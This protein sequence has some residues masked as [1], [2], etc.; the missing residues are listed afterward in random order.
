[1]RILVGWDDS[2]N[3]ELIGL[4]LN[5]D[6]H[7][8][9][10]VHDGD[11]L[12]RAAT[13]E[14]PWDVVLLAIDFPDVARGYEVFTELRKR[15]PDVPVVGA[16]RADE[17]VQ[18][19]RFLTAGMRTYVLRDTDGDFV[20]LLLSTLESTVQA[21]RA[22]RDQYI[23]GKLREEVEAVR[24]FGEAMIE[25]PPA[26]PPAYTIAARYEPSELHVRGG[27]P[28]A[29]A[30]G[31]FYD[32]FPVDRHRTAI[33][34]ADA[35]GHGMQACLS[36]SILQTHLQMLQQRRWRRPG[37]L[38]AEL[39]RRFCAHRIV[40]NRGNLA[41]FFCGI[42]HHDKHQL[43]WTSAGHPPP[44]M[45]DRNSETIAPI[46]P[47]QSAGPPLGVDENFHYP[48][49]TT[50]LPKRCRLIVY[51]DGLT[52]ASPDENSGIQFGLDGV[53][54]TLRRMR[55][56]SAE[57]VVQALLI[58]SHAFTRGGGRHDDTSVLVLERQG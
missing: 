56:R 18:L 17:I 38:T 10:V 51:T 42:L 13:Q 7:T 36:V 6:E 31:D 41:T 8:A 11:A 14:G 48:N 28:V 47:P 19:A 4:Y 29:L 25:Q 1:M 43:A 54:K 30:G 5:T 37:E 16:C 34:M 20:F 15:C 40:K 27:A 46:G 24:R 3:A 53:R 23:A 22:E 9:T 45:H 52:E 32:V 12:L 55:E 49:V 44:L 2:E 26:S 35:A 58:D 39:N 33:V 50:A 21:V 57:D